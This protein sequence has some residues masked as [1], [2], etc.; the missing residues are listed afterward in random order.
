MKRIL[1]ALLAVVLVT[2]ASVTAFGATEN[3][4]QNK[5]DSAAAFVLSEYS[6]SGFTADSAKRFELIVNSG[7]D[8]SAYKDAF[9]TSAA[10]ALASNEVG[11]DT[12]VQI[13]S[14]CI[15]LGEFPSSFSEE[16]AELM[17]SVHPAVSSPYNYVEAIAACAYFYLEESAAYY[18]DALCNYFV[19]DTGAVF[20]GSA[21]WMSGDD[22]AI[23]ILAL[24]PVAD[25]YGEY[26][27]EAVAVLDG[28]RSD[29]GYINSYTGANA[30]TTGL[31]L[32]A[33]SAIGDKEKADEAYE[34]L[35]NFYDSET[36]GFTAD[37]D[38]VYAT[39][40]A[41]T[42]LERYIALADEIAD[43]WNYIDG[44]WYYYKDGVA[45]KGWLYDGGKWYYLSNKTAAMQ[46]GWV[47]TNGKWYYLSKS[48]AMATGWQ[49][50][51]G[52]WYYLQSS[53]AMATGWQS[54][55]GKWYYLQ[56]SGAMATGWVK[57]SGKWYYLE[58]SGAMRTADLTYKGKVY[59]FNSSG[60]CI[61]P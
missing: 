16:K 25:D 33:Y 35:L 5:I 11:F 51:G 48:G 36:G 30:D 40:D 61:N 4:V 29:D 3:E 52:K 17:L 18:A 60:A 21:D 39:A 43:G 2:S 1:A 47:K 49:Y 14:A 37:F 42:G 26:I 10:D 54:V 20:W 45:Q 7:A 31:A 8:V 19:K 41:L 13:I 57:A 44:S 15:A 56:S 22:N 24:A 6:E 9:L 23:F 50:V 32:A 59:K 27:E 46:T 53:G 38:A 28:Y 34:M 58:A 55:G 12:K